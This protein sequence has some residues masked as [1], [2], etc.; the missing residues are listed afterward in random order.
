M[1]STD[2]IIHKIAKE[3]ASRLCSKMADL[4]GDIPLAEAEKAAQAWLTAIAQTN[5]TELESI[6][7]SEESVEELASAIFVSIV[8]D[9][10]EER[11]GTNP[12]A[13]E[14]N[15]PLPLNLAYSQ[16]KLLASI[17]DMAILNQDY[18]W[19]ENCNANVISLTGVLGQFHSSLNP[20]A[21]TKAEGIIWVPQ[22]AMAYIARLLRNS[23]LKMER[24][25]W[26]TPTSGPLSSHGNIESILLHHAAVLE[27]L[28][29][30]F[31]RPVEPTE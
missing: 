19:A 26:L 5:L 3:L 15:V 2:E 4:G 23:A 11:P 16:I 14:R 1:D 29:S 6:S 21:D 8:T 7:T 30:A 12:W 27:K 31:G 17:T 28:T 24:D 10:A 20:D 25:N 22:P 18:R 13:H 9:L